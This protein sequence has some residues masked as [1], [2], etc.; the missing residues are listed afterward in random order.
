M[1]LKNLHFKRIL[2]WILKKKKQ[3]KRKTAFGTEYLILKGSIFQIQNL[4]HGFLKTTFKLWNQFE[5]QVCNWVLWALLITF[6]DKHLN[7][8]INKNNCCHS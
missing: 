1:Q 8:L 3:K 5:I 4:V 7:I 6:A 2:S